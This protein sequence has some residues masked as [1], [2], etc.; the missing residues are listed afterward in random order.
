MHPKD[1]FKEATLR[2]NQLRWNDF[3]KVYKNQGN[4]LE[5]LRLLAGQGD[6][7]MKHGIAVYIY[8]A[9]TSMLTESLVNADGHLLIVPQKGALDIQTE[10][11]KLYVNVNE[12]V[13]IPQGVK[14]SIRLNKDELIKNNYDNVNNI[15]GYVLEVFDGHFELP[16]RGLIGSNGLANERDF[17]APVAYSDIPIQ[18]YTADSQNCSWTIY[19]KLG[20]E[21]SQL[22]LNHTPYDVGAWTGNLYPYKYDLKNFN[23]LGSVSFDHPDPSI[24]T[25]LTSLGRDGTAVA[26]FIIFPP[27]WSVQMDTFRPPYFHRNCMTEFMGLIQGKYDAKSS[28]QFEPGGASLHNSMVPH[29]PDKETYDSAIALQA[30]QGIIPESEE[31]NLPP[32]YIGYGS[33]AFMFETSLPLKVTTWGYNCGALLEDS[34]NCW[35]H[36]VE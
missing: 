7:E 32:V 30:V 3:G 12:I 1:Q 31:N 34:I 23:T 15:Q 8:N 35:K 21:Y 6:P 22:K 26:D 25:V 13:V 2:P 33:M 4:F 10:F 18:G 16:D 11:G 14:F 29:G 20:H 17:L 28:S 27:R 24:M 36:L 9:T 19:M 5:S